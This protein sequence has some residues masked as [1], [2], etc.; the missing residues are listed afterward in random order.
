[1]DGPPKA[2]PRRLSKHQLLDDEGQAERGLVNPAV[3]SNKYII[4]LTSQCAC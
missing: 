4:I 2:R 1:M 3:V